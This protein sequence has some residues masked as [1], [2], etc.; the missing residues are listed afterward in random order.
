MLHETASPNP[1]NSP[2]TLDYLL[3]PNV[4]ASCNY[5]VGRD[6]TIYEYL[7]PKLYVAWHAGINTNMKGYTLG[8]VNVHSIGIEVD[9]LCDGTPVTTVQFAALLE[10][11]LYL[12]DTFNIPIDTN[13]VFTHVG[14]CTVPGYRT[15]PKGYSLTQVLNALVPK[16]PHYLI[17]A[18]GKQFGAGEG[19][20]T[21]Y[22]THGV[23]VCGYPLCDEFTEK[24]TDGVTRAFMCFERLTL[25]YDPSQPFPWNLTTMLIPEANAKRK[26]KGLTV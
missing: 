21:F 25:K 24:G 8:D 10:L 17:D 11:V 14:I 13:H 19:F 23:V 15:D 3:G 1:N 4:Q 12:H 20:N 5:L 16:F 2:A 22:Q 26:L 6:G 7:D 9:G 18:S